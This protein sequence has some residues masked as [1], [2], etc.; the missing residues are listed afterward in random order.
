MEYACNGSLQQFLRDNRSDMEV[1]YDTISAS[2]TARD[3]ISFA[4]QVASGMEYISLNN[5]SYIEL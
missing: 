5:V 2:L 4:Y 3:L 1:H